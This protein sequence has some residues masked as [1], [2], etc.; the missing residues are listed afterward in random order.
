[1]EPHLIFL[2]L[3]VR[4]LLIASIVTTAFANDYIPAWAS[5]S[6]AIYYKA[7]AQGDAATLGSIYSSDAIIYVSPEDP[8]NIEGTSLKIK[9]REAIVEFFREDGKWLIIME[10]Y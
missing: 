6:T 4:A 5:E 1:M 9:G 7:N 3:L 8:E 2:R 10:H